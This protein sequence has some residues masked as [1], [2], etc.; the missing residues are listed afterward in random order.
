MANIGGREENY[1]PG[2]VDALSNVVLT[3]VFVL[4]IFVFALMFISS[5]VE[6]RVEEIRR[7]ASAAQKDPSPAE[8]AAIKK[9]EALQ[10]ELTRVR[11]EVQALQ[12]KL[13]DQARLPSA[14]ASTERPVSDG[15]ADAQGKQEAINVE[16]MAASVSTADATKDEV[17]VGHGDSQIIL[18]YPGQVTDL[19]AQSRQKLAQSLEVLEKNHHESKILLRSVIGREPYSVARRLA[20]YRALGVRNALVG[21]SKISPSRITMSIVQ[22]KQPEDGRVELVFSKQ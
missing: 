17:G 3:L 14:E 2:F 7:E 12:T 9:V 21:T 4:T 16:G 11:T 1:W 5:K 10:T 20:Y 15:K 6:K 8:V 22:P 13:A 18:K 19:G